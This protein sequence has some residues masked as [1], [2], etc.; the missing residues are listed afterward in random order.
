MN[1]YKNIEEY[2][3]KFPV[4]VQ[5]KLIEIRQAIKDEVPEVEEKISYGIPTATLKG[6]YLIYFAGYKNHV[7]VYPVTTKV[8]KTVKN[9]DKYRTGKGTLQ[10][11]L[12][13][14]LP[15]GL[16]RNV[17][18]VRLTEHREAMGS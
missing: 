14:P 3:G 11:S 1:S 2:I 4:G 17:I 10:F 5:K 15:V 13:K 16:I 9:I 7:S 8:E 6:K 18:K 12:D